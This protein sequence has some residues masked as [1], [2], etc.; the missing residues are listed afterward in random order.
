MGYSFTLAQKCDFPHTFQAYHSKES[1]VQNDIFVREDMQFTVVSES[2]KFAVHYDISGFNAVSPIDNNNNN[3]PD[4][5]DSTLYYID[6]AYYSEVELLGFEFEDYDANA[7]GTQ[8]YDVYIKELSN[9]PYYGGARP[10]GAVI[11]PEN[12]VV[13]TS[14]IV[15]D[16]NFS[17]EDNKYNTTGIDGLKITLFHEFFHS[18]QFQITTADFRVMGEMTATY[19]EYRFFPEIKD[20]IDWAAEWFDSPS[21]M[22]MSN[23]I[24]PSDGYGMSIFFHYVYETF[25]D[26]ILLDTWLGIGR[27]ENDTESLDRALTAKGKSLNDSF[28]DFTEWMFRTGDNAIEGY[29]FRFAEDLPNINLARTISFNGFEESINE[30][31]IPFT[32]CPNLIIADKDNGD[33]D[34]LVAMIINTDIE[35]GIRNRTVLANGELQVADKNIYSD[36]F[37]N[38]NLSYKTG[39]DTLFCYNFIELI[40]REFVEAFPNPYFKDSDKEMYLPIPAGKTGITNYEIYTVNMRLVANGF[41][42]PFN[43]ENKY[44]IKLDN[45][46]MTQL[47]SGVYI[48]KTESEGNIKLGKF[49]VQ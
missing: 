3:I 35:N 1:M 19:M 2:E 31:L 12:K 15:I 21:T 6:L 22:S 44:V 49:V 42:N 5:I 9:S 38:I 16:N 34:T 37:E 41:G 29:G 47:S 36:N 27:N 7:G 11:T 26:G 10:E 32:F 43:F 4:Y 39:S 18:I 25:G 8:M 13:N 24:N 17:N 28:C 33:S 45:F 48:Y 14:F 23:S 46:D 30:E 40:G 20:Y